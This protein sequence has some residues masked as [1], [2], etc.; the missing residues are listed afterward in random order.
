ML[1]QN[2]TAAGITL[3]G[4]DAQSAAMGFDSRRVDESWNVRGVGSRIAAGE[5]VACAMPAAE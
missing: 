1:G 5:K 3:A 4:A 2:R